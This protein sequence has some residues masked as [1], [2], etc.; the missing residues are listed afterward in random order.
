M[1]RQK[2]DGK[3]RIGGR[4]VGTPN[5]ATTDLKTWVAS[6]L[7]D[8]RE[9][10]IESLE[11]LEPSEYIRTFT[12]LPK[13]APTTPDDVLRKEKEMMQEL[14]LSLPEEAI[15]RVAKRLQEL[16]KKEE[17]ESKSR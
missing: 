8:G 1:A 4:S 15:D 7:E 16:Q 11:K 9:K 17:D 2:G 14:L 3:G 6:I 13:Q 12:G 10:F 5:K